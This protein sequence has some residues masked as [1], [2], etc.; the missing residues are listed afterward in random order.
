MSVFD[1]VVRTLPDGHQITILTPARRRGSG[2]G[3]DRRGGGADRPWGRSHVHPAIDA[4]AVQTHATE[5]SM[6]E[7]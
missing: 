4:I 2:D 3:P 6:R 5:V 1:R 7:R